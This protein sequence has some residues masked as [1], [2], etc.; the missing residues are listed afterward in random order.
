MK[1]TGIVTE[2]NPFHNGH[3]YHIEQTRLLT[4]PDV[5][6][7]VMSGHFVQRGEPSI[8]DKWKRTEIAL[9]HGV[10]LVIELPVAFATQSAKTFAYKSV[11]ILALA[12]VS[13]LVFGSESNDLETIKEISELNIN[14]DGLKES[15]RT[16][17]SYPKA[18][19][20]LSG[21]YDPNDI[22]GIGYC[23]AASQ[24]NITPH[25]IQRTNSYHSTDIDHPIASATAIRKALKNNQTIAHM[26]P[27]HFLQQQSV[28]PDWQ[29]YYPLL[30]HLLNTLPKTI[31]QEVFLVS[32]GIES[33]MVKQAMIC[34]N[35]HEFIDA[36]VN[37]RYSK[38]RI[39]RTMVHMLLHHTKKNIRE[40]PPIDTLRVLGFNQ[41]GLLA[42]QMYKQ[43][44]IKV[45]SRFNQIPLPYRHMEH[46]ATQVYASVFDTKEK[47]RIISRESQ[48]PVIIEI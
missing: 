21:A 29:L 19:G 17:N 36:C 43:K 2:Y 18:I 23:R 39:Q 15:M 28:Y 37:R 8:C 11:E 30:K 16:G 42:L 22:L 47:D 34:D 14:I 32:E 41:R 31:L 4:Q 7:A 13:D 1:I 27:M 24:F 40:L 33:H 6:V 12:Q 3:Q 9:N 48:G 10:D 44:E 46:K 26:T 38:A 35:A 20:L 25:T 5:L 45:A